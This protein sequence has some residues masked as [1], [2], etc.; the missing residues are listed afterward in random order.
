MSTI[1]LLEC[2]GTGTPAGDPSEVD[3]LK[4]HMAGKEVATESIALGSIK[5]QIGHA[6]TAAGAASIIKTALALYNKVLPASINVTTPNKQFNIETTP[7]Y[8]NTTTRPWIKPTTHPRRASV[9]A[10]G[11]GGTNFHVAMEEHQSEHTGA[12]RSFISAYSILLAGATKQAI[13]QSAKSVISRINEGEA[14]EVLFEIAEQ[15]SNLTVDAHLPRL[16]IGRA[17]V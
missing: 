7:Y 6:K 8:I 3:S 13:I 2:H 17:H 9:S 10:F 11:F 5:S 12:Y 15:S 14:E 1:G 4:I 16:E